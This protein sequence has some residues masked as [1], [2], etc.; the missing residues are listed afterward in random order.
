MGKGKRVW[1]SGCSVQPSLLELLPEPPTIIHLAQGRG[2]Y[3]LVPHDNP[4]EDLREQSN[5]GLSETICYLG[6]YGLFKVHGLTATCKSR[7]LEHTLSPYTKLNSKWLKDLNISHDTIK[8]LEES[9]GKTFCDVNRTNV[10]LGQSPKA[11]EIKPK[12]NT[13][14]GFP[15]GTVVKHLPANAGDMGSSPG[16]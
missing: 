11:K 4:P 12:I 16:P 10:F 14:G 15:G 7:K 3:I 6:V 13:W 5:T 2:K 8:L 1:M 9:I